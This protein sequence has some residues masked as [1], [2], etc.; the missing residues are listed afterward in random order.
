MWPT[1]TP[2]LSRAWGWPPP[3]AG[4][5]TQYTVLHA[6]LVLAVHGLTLDILDHGA[7]Q[8]TRHVCAPPGTGVLGDLF[9]F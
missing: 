6:V 3:G 2:L 9:G 1:H 4:V 7:P 8:H 5:W